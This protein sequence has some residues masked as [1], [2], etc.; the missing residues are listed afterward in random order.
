MAATP[1][2]YHMSEQKQK[3]KQSRTRR[4]VK[5]VLWTAGIFLLLIVFACLA[6]VLTIDR[7]IVPV[8]AWYT[9]IE[10]EGE[11]DVKVSLA[12][13]E[14]VLSGLKLIIRSGNV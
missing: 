4:I 11:P 1:F 9:G 12:D 8:C 14:I 3:K 10:V 2:P 7:W 5:A 13:R 6:A